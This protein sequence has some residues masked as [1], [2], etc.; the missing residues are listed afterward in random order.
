MDT[1]RPAG[2][3]F[4]TPGALPLATD[5]RLRLLGGV[6]TAG[7]LACSA[8]WRLEIASPWCASAAV[9]SLL[10]PGWG[11]HAGP[12]SRTA[13]A[14]GSSPFTASDFTTPQQ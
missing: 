3:P 13:G 1:P 9:A 12:P 4:A 11:R 6:L 8:P 14:A 7:A 10:V 5:R 2:H